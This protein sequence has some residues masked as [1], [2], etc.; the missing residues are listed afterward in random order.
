MSWAAHDLEPYLLRAKLGVGIS[1][2]F[3]LMGSYSPDIL[4]KW[5]VYGLDFSGKKHIVSDPVQLHRGW[6]GVGF[7]HSLI[8]AVLIAAVILLWSKHRIWAVSFLIGAWAHVFSDTLDSV[9]VMLFWP[10]TDW[11]LHFD[12]W[13]YVGEA[14]RRMDAVAYYTSLGG[15]WDV[16]W[17]VWLGFKWR[18]LT[19]EHF[20]REIFPHDPF[21]PWAQRKLGTVGALTVYRASAFFGFVSIVAWTLWALLINKTH[22]SFDW[23]LGGP[24]WAPRVGPPE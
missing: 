10:L 9:G 1:V 4:T 11:H 15:V 14:G 17:A 22:A 24:Q 2:P 7:T 16:F 12:V 21:W 8:F 5:A 18:T 3:C 23:S 6:P 13:Q 19:T 20:N